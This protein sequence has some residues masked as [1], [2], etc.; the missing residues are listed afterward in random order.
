VSTPAGEIHAQD[1]FTPK[2]RGKKK[3]PAARMAQKSAVSSSSGIGLDG[4]HSYSLTSNARISH[5]S[6]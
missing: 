5:S 2:V 3:A 4:S 1:S 6:F